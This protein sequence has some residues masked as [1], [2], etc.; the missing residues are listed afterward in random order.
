MAKN[1]RRQARHCPFLLN[2]GGDAHKAGKRLTHTHTKKQQ[3]TTG[4]GAPSGI[5]KSIIPLAFI[6]LAPLLL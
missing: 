1:T 6:Y 3:A 4:E 2:R 5:L